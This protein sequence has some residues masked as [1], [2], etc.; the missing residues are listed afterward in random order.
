MSR[1]YGKKILVVD[2][3]ISHRQMLEVVLTAADCVVYTADDGE[4]AIAL[5]NKISFDLI[6]MDIC[7]RRVGGIEAM[8]RIHEIRPDIP[9][10]LMTAYADIKTADIINDGARN[11]LYKPLDIEE[12]ISQVESVLSFYRQD[13]R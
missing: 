2:D 6:I 7:M 11:C 10:I 9:V 13:Q 8:K 5:V 3:D 12:L 1:V 4:S